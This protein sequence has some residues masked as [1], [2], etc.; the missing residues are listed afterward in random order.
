MSSSNNTP[1]IQ[2]SLSKSTSGT[3]TANASTSATAT[4]QPS[5]TSSLLGNNNKL[6]KSV[7]KALK[8]QT[9]NFK[10][11]VECKFKSKSSGVKW[12]WSP[13]AKFL[14]CLFSL[15]DQY[16][17][18]SLWVCLRVVSL[19]PS[20]SYLSLWVLSRIVFCE[21]SILIDRFI[22]FQFQLKKSKTKQNQK[23]TSIHFVLTAI[24]N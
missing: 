18:L 4:P 22:Q 17:S 23:L 6:Y 16:I 14:S 1:R 5:S 20:L 12:K 21:L 19:S 10:I 13:T 11:N 2:I 8:N 3:G 9:L 7:R 24:F 15:F